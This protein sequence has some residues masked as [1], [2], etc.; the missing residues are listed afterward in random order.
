MTPL[1]DAQNKAAQ[2]E[3]VHME[4]VRLV[5]VTRY[6]LEKD[7]NSE[8]KNTFSVLDEWPFWTHGIS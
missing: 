3:A 6:L 4:F 2:N 7:S 1:N 8:K 5:I